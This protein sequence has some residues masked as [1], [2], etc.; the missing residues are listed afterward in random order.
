MPTNAGK[1]GSTLMGE[2]GGVLVGFP[3]ERRVS[4]ALVMMLVAA[5][6]ANRTL[7]QR[8]LGGWAFALAF[9]RDACAS[10][11][12]AY[13]A[14]TSLAPSRRCR[15]S[16]ALI[17]EIHLIAGLAPL[18]ET[19]VRA[20]PCEKLYATDASPDGAGGPRP[21]PRTVYDLAE[22]KES[23][24]A[25]IGRAKNHRATCMTDVQRLLRLR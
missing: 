10:L 1:S 9:W 17:D 5:T 22:E 3:F 16:G 7:F 4:L 18:L 20:E 21:S 15:V 13:S 14:A 6:G 8:L 11:Y 12:V 19:N 2:E 24:F 25:L 23:T